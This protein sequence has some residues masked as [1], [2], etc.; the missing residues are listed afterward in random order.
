MYQLSDHTAKWAPAAMPQRGVGQIL[1]DRIAKESA[2][3]VKTRSLEA[4]KGEGSAT[5][6]AEIPPSD[7]PLQLRPANR[8]G[9]LHRLQDLLTDFLRTPPAGL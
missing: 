9:N 6:R 4:V 2:G 8:L 3:K 7:L 1:R 5:P